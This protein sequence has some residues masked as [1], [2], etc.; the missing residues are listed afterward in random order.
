MSAIAPSSL[1][2][3]TSPTTYQNTLNNDKDGLMVSRIRRTP[4]VEERAAAFEHTNRVA[5]DAAE[6]E[7]LLRE[8]KSA[9]L[10]ALRLAA[11]SGASRD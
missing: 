11:E 3:T 1:N 9:K 6:D 8:E 7:R 10:W 5:Q 2:T 4:T